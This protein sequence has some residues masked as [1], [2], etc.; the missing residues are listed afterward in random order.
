MDEA[1]I[2]IF[3]YSL[4]P[5]PQKVNGM[6]HD[7]IGVERTSLENQIVSMMHLLLPSHENDL[8]GNHFD[9]VQL[10]EK[11]PHLASASP[12]HFPQISS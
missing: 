6:I 10:P 11:L 9:F 1:G 7:F 5:G 12:P 3:I 4:E 2:K 8:S